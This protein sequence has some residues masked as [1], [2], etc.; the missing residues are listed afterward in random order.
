[1][2]RAR[3][4]VTAAEIFKGGAIVRVCSAREGAT[5]R[6][7]GARG[8]ALLALESTLDVLGVRP[9]LLANRRDLVHEGDGCGEEG[10]DRMLDHFCRF[11]PHPYDIDRKW[12]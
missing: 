1:N 9:H 6:Q 4:P 12:R 8:D 7:I 11:D 5:G 3:N 10:V 2:Q